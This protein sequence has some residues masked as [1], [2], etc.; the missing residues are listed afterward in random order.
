MA[1]P[2]FVDYLAPPHSFKVRRFPHGGHNPGRVTDSVEPGP[3]DKQTTIY[4]CV[5]FT[6]LHAVIVLN[7]LH[8]FVDQSISFDGF[9]GIGTSHIVICSQSLY[10]NIAFLNKRQSDGSK[11]SAKQRDSFCNHICHRYRLVG[12]PLSDDTVPSQCFHMNQ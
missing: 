7:S 3:Y 5:L 12:S 8:G 2:G 6:I 11:L 4:W 1:Q 10:T 9:S